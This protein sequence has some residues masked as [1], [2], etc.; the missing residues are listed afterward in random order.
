MNF[1]KDYP[2]TANQKWCLNSVNYGCRFV[3]LSLH[4]ANRMSRLPRGYI[5]GIFEAAFPQSIA[6]PHRNAIICFLK[7]EHLTDK[8]GDYHVSLNKRLKKLLSETSG[9][10]GISNSFSDLYNAKI[11]FAQAEAA[12]E[13]GMITNS[14]SDLYYFQSYALIS[15][16]INSTG[17]LPAEAYFSERLQKLIE[18]DKTGPI[19]YLDTLR[20][21][22]RNS[23]SYSQ[24]A[25]ELYIHRSTVIDRIQRIERELNVD[26]KDADTCLHLEIILKAMEIENM[27]QK[28]WE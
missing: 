13:N 6:F 5:C 14:E 19:S 17:N 3:C 20:V 11:A 27:V 1:I 24:T 4:S 18:H 21:F 9:I 7:V 2:L 8:S 16:I 12:I 25:Q 10:A 26:L 15:L 23:H 22:L 28:A